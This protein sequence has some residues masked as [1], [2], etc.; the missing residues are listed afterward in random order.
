M[1]RH[2]KF[3]L[4]GA[5]IG[6]AVGSIAVVLT[7]SVFALIFAVKYA[8]IGGVLML[9]LSLVRAGVDWLRNVLFEAG[10]ET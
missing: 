10:A 1:T 5:L 9:A 3:A 4:M 7:G 2:S 8:V 6:A